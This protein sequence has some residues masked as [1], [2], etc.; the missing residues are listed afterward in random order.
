MFDQLTFIDRIRDR[1]KKMNLLCL[2]AWQLAP[3][4]YVTHISGCGLPDQ[5]VFYHDTRVTKFRD[6]HA[7]SGRARLLFPLISGGALSGSKDE[8]VYAFRFGDIHSA[9]FISLSNTLHYASLFLAKKDG[10]EVDWLA[11]PEQIVLD[12][13]PAKQKT[14][15]Q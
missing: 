11:Q 2:G 14:D 6:R 10:T 15:A 4:V 7:M 12:F 13:S 3:N 9:P 8:T 5:Y 1:F